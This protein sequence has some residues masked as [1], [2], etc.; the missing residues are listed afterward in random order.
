MEK[1]N[2]PKHYNR[3]G[4]KECIEE[5]LDIYGSE[6]VLAF[7]ELN[8]YKYKYRAGLKGSKKEDLEKAEWYLNKKMELK[9]KMENFNKQ[10][11]N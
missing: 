9:K 8:A 7:C 4:R 10:N 1:V 5:M 11:L 3:P 2:H 6:K